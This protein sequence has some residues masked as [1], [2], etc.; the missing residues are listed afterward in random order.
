MPR[1]P[2]TLLLLIVIQQQLF[3][4]H[5]TAHDSLALAIPSSSTK[6]LSDFASYISDHFTSDSSKV[7]AIFVWI[8][9]NISY[10]V[11]KS[12]SRESLK[13]RQ[14]VDDVL[15][16]RS[17][18][19]QGYADLFHELGKQCG[20][21]AIVINGYTKQQGLIDRISHAW[22]GAEINRQWFLFDPTWAAG[23]V[24]NNKFVKRFS[25]QYFMVMPSE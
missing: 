16:T 11:K 6:T 10:N 21:K 19:C 15:R 25:E 23:Y 13:Q 2:I 9:N 18:V 12:S 8:A 22:I 14:P 24:Q 7:R 4:Q 3:S 17:A 20:I 1:I 5:L